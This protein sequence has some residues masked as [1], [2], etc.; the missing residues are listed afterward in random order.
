[1]YAP[2]RQVKCKESRYKLGDQDSEFD[3]VLENVSLT[4]L[5]IAVFKLRLEGYSLLNV[6]K[7]LGEPIGLVSQKLINV[8]AVLYGWFEKNREISFMLEVVHCPLCEEAVVLS[9]TAKDFECDVCGAD[10]DRGRRV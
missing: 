2:L 5:E 8:K 6:A 9:H 7:V 4:D 10:I 1:M 3:D